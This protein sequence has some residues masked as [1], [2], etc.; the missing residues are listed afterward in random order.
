MDTLTTEQL[1]RSM[2]DNE[3][4]TLINVLDEDAFSTNHIPGSIN[5]PV[6]RDD[7]VQTVENEVADKDA[8]VIVYCASTD[9]DASF[10]AAEKLDAAGFTNVYDYEEGMAGW[11]DADNLVASS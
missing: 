11:R 9:C 4:F 3:E 7:F 10:K 6:N 5:I 8:H 1:E 2:R